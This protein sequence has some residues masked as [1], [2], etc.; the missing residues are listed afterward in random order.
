MTQRMEDKELEHE[1]VAKG[2]MPDMPSEEAIEML[3][4]TKNQQFLHCDAE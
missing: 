2:L 3:S 1:H 4:S